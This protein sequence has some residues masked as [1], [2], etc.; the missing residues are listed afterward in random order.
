MHMTKQYWTIRLGRTEDTDAVVKLVHTVHGDR[1]PELNR[2]YWE[3]RYLNETEFRADILIAEYQGE[4]IGIRPMV[5]FDFQWGAKH[6]TGAMLTGVLTHPDHRRRGVFRSLVDASNERVARLGA[7]F[8]MTM[9]NDNSLRGFVNW[10]EWRYPGRIPLYIKVVDGRAMLTPKAGRIAAHLVGWTPQ[11]FFRNRPIHAVRW[12]LDTEPTEL[13]PEELDEVFD[14]FARACGTLMIR[15]TA[16]YWNWRYGRKPSAPYRTFLARRS[17]AVVGAVVTSMQ[18]RM[19]LDVGMVI[20]L[21][22][23]GGLTTLGQLLRSAETDLIS[24]RLGLITCQATSPLLCRALEEQG[25]RCLSSRWLPKQFH[26]LYRPTGVPGLPR[27]PARLRDW[28]LTFGDS[29]NA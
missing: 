16:A 17:G 25:Y 24:R 7:Q 22:A 1:Y 18:R 29:D 28:H 21:V 20:D 19:G 26:F 8:S 11:V 6:L 27:Q 10:R 9:P 13:V 3:W 2:S 12:G 23:R 14:E 15:R 5:L 4:P